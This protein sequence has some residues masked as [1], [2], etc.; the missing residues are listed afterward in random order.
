MSRSLDVWVA[1]VPL[2]TVCSYGSLSWTTRFPYGDFEASWVLSVPPGWRHPAFTRGNEVRIMYGGLPLW[3]GDIGDTNWDTGEMHAEG[4]IRR[5][6]DYLALHY[7]AVAS[8]IVPTRN[9]R[10]A[11]DDAIS[12]PTAMGRPAIEWSRDTSIPDI[13]LPSDNNETESL[14]ILRLLDAASDRGYGTPHMGPD[15]T[16]RLLPDPMAAAYTLAFQVWPKMVD[17][18]EAGGPDRATRIRVTYLL[19]SGLSWRNG[20]SYTAGNEVLFKGDLWKRNGSGAGDVPS[21]TSTLWSKLDVQPWDPDVTSA[22][23]NP[24]T[25]YVSLNNSIY[26]TVVVGSTATLAAPPGAA[27]TLLGSYPTSAVVEAYDQNVLPYREA[28]VDATELGDITAAEASDIADQA[29]AEG[30]R[31]VFDTD[32][33]LT[34]LTAANGSGEPINPLVVRDGQVGRIWGATHPRLGQSF[35]DLIAGEVTVSD[36]ETSTPTAVVKPYNKPA[37]AYLEVLEASLNA[38]RSA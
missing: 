30:L 26:K 7:D 9:P 25:Y 22:D 6:E 4:R 8:G 18:G 2:S 12:P 16:I 1:G 13:T 21:D 3:L 27:W 5:A 28:T 38:R 33:T 35:I 11:V 34:P 20:V 23:Y 10:F 24:G 31:P 37:R 15:G 14:S 19:A 32:I 17:V 36:A 29:L